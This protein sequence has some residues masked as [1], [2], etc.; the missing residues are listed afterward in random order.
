MFLFFVEYKKSN[1][2]RFRLKFSNSQRMTQKRRKHH[3]SSFSI[4]TRTNIT[5]CLSHSLFWYS[6][7]HEHL[8]FL[9]V[10]KKKY[11][12]IFRLR[13]VS[14][15]SKNNLYIPVSQLQSLSCISMCSEGKQT[16]RQIDRHTVKKK[17]IRECQQ[18]QAMLCY[19]RVL[20][21]IYI[22]SLY[23]SPSSTMMMDIP[24]CK[25]TAEGWYSTFGTHERSCWYVYMYVYCP[26]LMMLLLLKWNVCCVGVVHYNETW[27]KSER[28]GE[29]K[30]PTKKNIN[31]HTLL[32]HQSS[33]VFILFCSPLIGAHEAALTKK[34]K[35]ERKNRNGHI[36]PRY[37]FSLSLSHLLSAMAVFFLLYAHVPDYR[38][39]FCAYSICVV[40]DG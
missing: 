4:H 1:R 30:K 15:L 33:D 40:F 32:S 18:Q 17:R 31:I 5:L 11:L 36:L 21:A 28:E 10:Q 6:K 14:F 26:V 20:F 37:P 23:R 24:R 19:E 3:S 9:I 13:C 35:K 25:R 39:L 16:D 29:K 34:K 7:Y 2:I 22:L 8:P 27:E 12:G 38:H